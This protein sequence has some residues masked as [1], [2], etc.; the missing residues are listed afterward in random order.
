[1]EIDLALIADAATVDA[2]GKLNILGV[3]DRIS[4]RGFP[5]QHPH[6]SL[7][8]RIGASVNEGGDHT[9]KIELKDPDGREVVHPITGKIKIGP[10]PVAVGGRVRIPQV[11]NLEHL[12]FPKE[13]R[14]SFDIS[15]DG[16]HQT[17]V[18]LY[19][20]DASPKAPMAQA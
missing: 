13:G 20:H 14:Y 9:V 7:V 5:A 17:S 1:M 10:G 6:I 4:T 18:P 15:I 2:A 19:L 11:V 16:E 8:L 3:F 12:T